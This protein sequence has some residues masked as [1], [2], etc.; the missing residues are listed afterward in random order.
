MED[1]QLR[2]CRCDRKLRGIGG[3]RVVG[4]R[5]FTLLSSGAVCDG[6][7]GG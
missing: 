6:C 2:C 1:P 7:L 3:G 4:S 5:R